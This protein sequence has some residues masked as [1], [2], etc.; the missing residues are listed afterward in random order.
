MLY[1][2]WRLP[3]TGIYNSH[4]LIFTIGQKRYSIDGYDDIMC[5]NTWIQN[6]VK[7]R[8]VNFYDII[9]DVDY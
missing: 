4:N 3:K 8:L 9:T 1:A 7:Y 5:F 6:Y 2:G